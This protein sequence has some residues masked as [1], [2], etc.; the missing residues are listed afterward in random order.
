MTTDNSDEKD[1]VDG[2]PERLGKLTRQGDPYV[3]RSYCAHFNVK[4]STVEVYCR[5][6]GGEAKDLQWFKLFRAEGEPRLP[7]D[8]GFLARLW[9]TPEGKK[10]TP[11]AWIRIGAYPAGILDSATYYCCNYVQVHRG[12]ARCA[13]VRVLERVFEHGTVLQCSYD[14]SAQD[15]D[16]NDHVVQIA[17]VNLD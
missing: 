11:T 17:F 1:L 2:L 16:F 12:W 6:L 8:E 14:D 4:Q 13:A 7:P 5:Q 3:L 10:P 9:M 15:G